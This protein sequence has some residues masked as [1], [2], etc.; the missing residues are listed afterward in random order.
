MANHLLIVSG[1]TGGKVV[2]AFKKNVYQQF[3][4]QPP[5]NIEYLYVDSSRDEVAKIAEWEVL[6][7]SIAL[8]TSNF[9][10]LKSDNLASKFAEI[11]RYPGVKEFIGDR[12]EWI[13][14]IND[15]KGQKT[16][17]MQ[18]RRMGRI[19]FA[20]NAN[21][22]NSALT[23]RVTKL[24]NNTK[25]SDIT[26]HVC[27]GLAGGTGSGSIVDIIT[28]I[29]NLFPANN[30][31]Y[32][33]LLYVYLPEDTTNWNTVLDFYHANGYAALLELNALSTG[34]LRPYDVT[35]QK[36]QLNVDTPFTGCYVFSNQNENG[37][38]VDKE[39][40]LPNIV[41]DFLY[42]KTIG[43]TQISSELHRIE[44]GE[45][46]DPTPEMAVGSKTAERSK[47]FLSFGIKRIAI[48]EQEIKEY[49]TFNLAKQ[50]ALQLRFNNWVD[51]SGFA[52]SPKNNS[53]N[54]YVR[55]DDKLQGW[56][57]T[58]KHITLSEPVLIDESSRKWKAFETH[59]RDKLNFFKP[60]AKQSDKKF[61]IDSL[62]S[63]ALKEF[64]EDF[65]R[66]GG[67]VKFFEAKRKDKR[68]MAREIRGRIEAEFFGEWRSGDLSIYDLGRKIDALVDYLRSDI[69]K[70]LDDKIES[71]KKLEEK[72]K[73]LILQNDINWAKIGIIS[74]WLNKRD[75]IFEAQVITIQD[76]YR[77]RTEIEGV[78]FAREFVPEI[79]EQ[80]ELLKHEITVAGGTVNDGIAIFEQNIQSRCNDREW[81]SETAADSVEVFKQQL[82]PFYEPSR[83]KDVVRRFSRDVKI[84]GPQTAKVRDAITKLLGEDR[85][86]FVDFNNRLQKNAFSTELEKVCQ[87]NALAIEKDL[88][89]Q[90]RLLGMNVIEKLQR[91]YEG[92]KS[93]LR[94]LTGQLMK[95]AGCYILF[96]QNEVGK[97]GDGLSSGPAKRTLFVI[98]PKNSTTNYATFI[99]DLK[100][101]FEFNRNSQT[102]LKFLEADSS[103]YRITLMAVTSLFPLRYL[104][105]TERL[106]EKYSL[107]L[108]KP[109]TIRAKMLLHLQDDGAGLPSLFAPTQQELV[110][111]L[112]KKRV[113]SVPILLLA[114]AM[115]IVKERKNEEGYSKLAL[116]KV[117]MFGDEESVFFMEKSLSSSWKSLAEDHI[118][119]LSSIVEQESQTK[120]RHKSRKDELVEEIKNTVIQLK[121][122]GSDADYKLF[123]DAA[124]KLITELQKDQ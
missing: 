4:N 19:L 61:W 86:T 36:G 85:L 51:V 30:A 10:E 66:S 58:L 2:R 110:D 60:L 90:E 52:N 24:R 38:T 56:Y 48:P 115:K 78:K 3:R 113:D 68:D 63:L 108:Q 49:L 123:K 6:G 55:R 99:D 44:S 12:N 80:L 22:F 107:R 103:E 42:Q 96:N 102:E 118:S 54:E 111:L 72:A 98:L 114:Y 23:D 31:D 47:R 75:E 92:N 15:S 97:S 67:V 1:G 119:Q 5:S 25:E 124:V 70:G 7:E 32:T 116:V 26:F 11:E 106:R 21:D 40:E 121:Q 62:K 45:N 64:E 117:D 109:D 28:Q 95:Y 46:G 74:D 39:T 9:L 16:A 122:D 53:F 77:V 89:K 27:A 104:T 33:I 94:D 14:L 69:A 87:E 88:A 91:R 71:L 65:R 50:A 37:I 83:V 93:A 120:Y 59:W 41:A 112:Y 82:V 34:A 81:T 79:L 35:G 84:Q 105:Q 73:E 100:D 57:L 20:G 13:G 17:G 76:E 43:L 8:G 29:R 18:R 101:A